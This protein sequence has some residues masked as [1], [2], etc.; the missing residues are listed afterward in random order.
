[1]R[2]LILPRCV[3]VNEKMIPELKQLVENELV[4]GEK[5]LWCAQP[6]ADKFISSI[7]PASVIWLSGLF[8][9]CV[10][11]MGQAGDRQGAVLPGLIG[12]L[13]LVA[14][15]GVLEI[16]F[17]PLRARQ[18][19][20]A[21]TDKRAF[22]L[23]IRSRFT[24][25]ESGRTQLYGKNMVSEQK[26]TPGQF[27]LSNLPAQLIF[28]FLAI[29]VVI[30][31]ARRFD[32][33]VALG[34]VFVVAGWILH[35]YQDLRLPLARFRDTPKITYNVGDLLVSIEDM[36]YE[37]ISSLSIRKAKKDRAD[38]FVLS[39]SRGVLRMKCST[40]A[41]KALAILDQNHPKKP[42]K[43]GNAEEEKGA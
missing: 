17:V 42:E 15:I 14:L 40:D 18:T 34:F 32:V 16:I 3:V 29:D 28:A 41:T 1:M 11:V 7:V 13:V 2:R 31:A 23:T 19:V 30:S 8:L 6:D 33:F 5:L 20:Y 43:S 25:D 24:H 10:G 27:Y 9:F 38:I 21:L 35:W 39:K 36:P 22:I 37:D 12:L 4:S 26:N